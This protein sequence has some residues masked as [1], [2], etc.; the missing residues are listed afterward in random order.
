MSRKLGFSL[1]RPKDDK[2]Y[3]LDKQ[4]SRPHPELLAPGIRVKDP[5]WQ[6]P[7]KYY[8]ERDN[9]ILRAPYSEFME[10]G[11]IRA[12]LLLSIRVSPDLEAVAK[13]KELQIDCLR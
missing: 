8:F 1:Y 6:E 13:E 11:N 2:A 12:A 5:S 9:K 7:V 4:R 3:F 10:Y